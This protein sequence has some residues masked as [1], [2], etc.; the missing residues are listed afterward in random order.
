ML[1]YLKKIHYKF[2]IIILTTI[3]AV[4]IIE[5]VHTDIIF[6][7]AG[8]VNGIGFRAISYGLLYE[9]S[10]IVIVLFAIVR[11]F[12]HLKANKRNKKYAV[13]ALVSVLIFLV[14]GYPCSSSTSRERFII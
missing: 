9:L 14:T 10:K 3:L 2:D 4:S 8:L 11:I 6:Y 5:T 1:Q 12:F 7:N 13:T